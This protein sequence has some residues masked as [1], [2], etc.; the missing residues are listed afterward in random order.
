MGVSID[1]GAAKS[2][3]DMTRTGSVEP[4]EVRKHEPGL[5]GARDAL[6]PELQP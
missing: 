3:I 4:A 5:A 1:Y 2:L 6:Q